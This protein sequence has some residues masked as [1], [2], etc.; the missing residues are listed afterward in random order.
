MKLSTACRRYVSERELRPETEHKLRHR[1][2]CWLRYG[3]KP[4]TPLPVR[5]FVSF[6]AAAADAGLS[7][8][9]IEETVNDIARIAGTSE[10]GHALRGWK[11]SPCGRVPSVETISKAY[12]N[13]SATCW[14]VGPCCRT[15]EL[16]VV[17]N[18][19]WWRAFLTFSFFTGLRLRDIR[20]VTWADFDA[21][22]WQASKT[23]KIHQY[24]KCSIVSRHLQPLRESGSDRIFAF[25]KS[26]ERLVRRELKRISDDQIGGSQEI[27]RSSI[28]TWS[29]ASPDAGRMI[30]GTDLG[31]MRHY[32]DV[33][34]V[35][36]S[37]LP[38]LQWPEAMLLPS[39]R[40]QRKQVTGRLLRLAA[41]LPV[42]RL[43]DLE[44]VASAFAG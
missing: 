34:R 20:T 14:P 5:S 4:Q 29:I 2:N 9:T 28:T 33:R 27:R 7:R 39:E 11:A 6:R 36:E 41:R 40:D 19:T 21:Q 3:G 37:A 44:R 32:L 1:L 30:H 26:Q 10:T 12:E 42:E 31:V 13:A 23:S 43:D 15:P 38:R 16:M 8:R 24:P 22:H 18:G 17:D 35:L 25:S